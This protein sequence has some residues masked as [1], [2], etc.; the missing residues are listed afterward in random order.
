MGRLGQ[1]HQ[2]RD[3]STHV[4]AGVGPHAVLLLFLERG[5]H[6]LGDAEA[7][8]GEAAGKVRTVRGVED[9]AV[10]V[11]IAAGGAA[12]HHVLGRLDAVVGDEGI[13]DHQGLRAAAA[14]ADG[15]PVVADLVVAAR[16][17]TEAV[18]QLAFGILAAHADDGP[19]GV[20]AAAAP[21]HLAAEQHAALGFLDGA[22][23]CDA[24][25]G[26]GIRVF[27]PDL[28][29]Q[30]LGEH[31]QLVA[32][33]AQQAERPGS[34]A[35]GAGQGSHAV[36]ELG[37]GDFQTAVC[38]RLENTMHTDALQQGDV[39]V[40]HLALKLCPGGVGC[41]GRQNGLQLLEHG[42]RS[43]HGDMSRQI[44]IVWVLSMHVVDPRLRDAWATAATHSVWSTC[45]QCARP[46]SGPWGHYGGVILR[47]EC[48]FHGQDCIFHGNP[49]LPHE[50]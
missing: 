4:G 42:I 10:R 6:A 15:V 44:L 30:L 24:A 7:D 47:T 27:A 3:G 38:L 9:L 17:Y 46:A 41:D 21:A 31:R 49:L 25:A 33:G 2:R 28:V 18:D 1:T 5:Q 14:L 23:R 40:R 22:E 12:F 39:L 45:G 48:I 43:F 34:T 20:V 35:A 11:Q 19:L 32:V 13:L 29:L 8:G 26:G 37:Q 16:Q 36:G 50:P